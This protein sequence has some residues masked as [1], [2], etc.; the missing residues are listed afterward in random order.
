[1]KNEL[2]D[3]YSV[4]A[5]FVRMLALLNELQKNLHG[6]FERV[7]LDVEKDLLL[8]SC[9]LYDN[10]KFLAVFHGDL[11]LVELCVKVKKAM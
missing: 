4:R 3:R 8:N 1:M 7:D 11:L 6:H 5:H 2:V 9:L 10:L